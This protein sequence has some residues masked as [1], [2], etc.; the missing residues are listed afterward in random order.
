MTQSN[1]SPNGPRFWS[2]IETS[3]TIGKGRA[4]GLRRL[5]LTPEDKQM[6]DVFASWCTEAGYALRVDKLGNMFARREG[7]DPS[8]PPVLIGSHLDTQAAGGRFDGIVG[9]L[10]GLEVLRSL[11]D[12]GVETKRAVEVVNWTNEEGAR[13]QPPMMCSAVYAGRRTLDWALDRRDDAGVRFGD[14]LQDINYAGQE[15]VAGSPDSYFELHIEQG[16]ELEA[17]HTQVGL[18]T[19]A[20]SAHGKRIVVRGENG[21]SGPSA[22]RDRRNALVGASM[23]AVA[24]N[25]IGWRY[26]DRD[27]KT[28]V[29]RLEAWPNRP[30]I[31]SDEATLYVDYRSPEAS[32][33]KV[34]SDEIEACLAD[35]ARRS[36]CDIAVAEAWSFDQGKFDAELV[37]SLEASA[38]RLGLTHL[39]MLSQAGH[40][41]YNLGHICPTA[42]IFTPC[43]G[44]VTHN[45]NEDTTLEDQ[46]PGLTL[47]LSAVLERASL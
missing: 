43:K 17:T 13:F 3:A 4:G 38:E 39:R 10:G 14:A 26:A 32:L 8:L 11:D 29:A 18:V 27:G 20:Y 31:I 33:A 24:V 21:H 46:M 40:D 7:T 16:P 2:T 30:G 5:T 35:C 45:E 37:S 25:E 44:G 1:L 42:L 19:G 23:V 34:M 41:A 12:A 36:Q 15:S 47:L 6:R 28:T 22:M 9:V